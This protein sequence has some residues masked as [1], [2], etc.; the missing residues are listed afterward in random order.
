MHPVSEPELLPPIT[1]RRPYTATRQ[2]F[3]ASSNCQPRSSLQSN[4]SR[5]QCAGSMADNTHHPSTQSIPSETPNATA[6]AV[7][8]V[9]AR[10][11]E[12]LRAPSARDPTGLQAGFQQRKPGVK[13]PLAIRS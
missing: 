1:H 11:H 5:L 7:Y 4:A 10:S 2:L 13:V 12:R 8:H 3:E 6:D 9:V